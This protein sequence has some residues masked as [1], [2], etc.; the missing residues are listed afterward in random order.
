MVKPKVAT[1]NTVSEATVKA[2]QKTLNKLQRQLVAANKRNMANV[3]KLETSQTAAAANAT[4]QLTLLEAAVTNQSK[5]STEA[6]EEQ[7]SG[8]RLAAAQVAQSQS[9]SVESASIADYRAK[10]QKDAYERRQLVNALVR[11]QQVS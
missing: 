10:Q 6:P 9:D 7:V 11:N 3:K 5:V 8:L 2:H 4:E 1:A